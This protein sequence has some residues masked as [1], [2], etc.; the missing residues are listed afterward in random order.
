M[1]SQKNNNK[2]E[3]EVLFN[4]C[5]VN[6][7]IS[8]KARELYKERKM[9]DSNYYLHKRND[10]ILIQIYNELGNEFDEKYSKTNIERIPKKYENYYYIRKGRN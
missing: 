3:I 8:N 7:K 2:E 5:Y 6:W 1:I 10:P 4:D 9:K